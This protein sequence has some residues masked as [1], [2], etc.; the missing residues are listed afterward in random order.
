MSFIAACIQTNSQADVSANIAAIAPL[1]AQAAVQG[2][3]LIVLPENAFA[4]EAPGQPP[5][6]R[7]TLADHPG[8][9]AAQGWARQ[10]M[11]WLLVGSVAVGESAEAGKRY[12]RSL[13]INPQGGIQ[14]A[15]DKIHLFDVTLPGGETY[16]ESAKFH[17]G[18][19]LALAR[20]PL[21]ALGLT[22]CYDVRF[23]YLYRSLAERGAEVIAVPA[24][25]TR[26]TGEAHWHVLL[27]ARAIENGCFIVAPAQ[28][29][30]HPG[31]RNTYGH[32]L[33]VDPWGRILA[34]GSADTPGVICAE[35]DIAEV[36]KMRGRI[37]SL[38]HTRAY[39]ADATQK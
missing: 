15:Y 22:V 12:N 24:A 31:G 36:A 29:G 37:P 39:A 5:Q 30:V 1:V 32:S 2:A 3:A 35:I 33:I 34:E 14:A 19:Q 10:F 4:M 8:V 28:C 27:R 26:T 23:P 11:A 38:A 6:A 7:Y 20:T 9:A 16:Q 13:L 17:Y 18:E 21:A 25:F